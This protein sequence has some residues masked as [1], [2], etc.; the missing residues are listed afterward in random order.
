MAR[1]L[2]VRARRI[3]AGELDGAANRIAGLVA[4]RANLADVARAGTVAIEK[5][6][7]HVIEAQ[8]AESRQMA[9][10]GS[11]VQPI[12]VQIVGP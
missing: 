6:A 5:T 4:Q 11:D 8:G 2:L 3:V 12:V 10:D 1:V 7:V 9:P